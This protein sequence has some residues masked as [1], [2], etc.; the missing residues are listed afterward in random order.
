MIEY[1]S[2]INHRR[3]GFWTI[4]GAQEHLWTYIRETNGVWEGYTIV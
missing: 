1:H 2:I 3:S 4:M